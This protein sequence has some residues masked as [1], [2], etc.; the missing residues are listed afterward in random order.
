MTRQLAFSVRSG[1]W[2]TLAGMLFFAGMMATG[3]AYN[4]T[5]VQFGLLDLG[6]RLVGM[7]RQNLALSMACLAL[8]TSLVA[9][10]FGL[11]MARRSWGRQFQTKLRLAFGV[12]LGQ[13]LLTAVAPFIRSQPAFLAWIVGASLALGVGV[14]V[15][16]GMTVD[17]VPVRSRSYVAALITAGAYFPAAVVSADWTVETFAAGMVP[18]MVAGALALGGLAFG[19]LDLVRQLAAQHR[20]PDFGL[21]RFVRL[22]TTPNAGSQTRVERSLFVLFILMFGIYFVDSLGFLRLAETPLF[23]KTAWRSPELNTRLLIGSAHIVA[24]LIAGVLYAALDER[25]LFLWIFG[26]FALVHLMYTVSA[27]GAPFGEPSLAMPLLYAVA[28]SLYTVINFA[29]WADVSTPGTISRNA[30]LGVA[31]SAWTATFISTGLALQLRLSG[32]SLAAHLRLVDA[33]A[34]LFFL[35]VLLLLFFAPGTGGRNQEHQEGR[36]V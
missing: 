8:L 22:R 12:V 26:I 11:L 6:S 18:L 28:V 4:L 13:T 35:L 7:S 19:R 15:T 29:I 1:R 33:L 10:L 5:F 16:F 17:L 9:V 31:L 25:E 14:P 34:L 32:M 2:T 21:G 30:A 3:Y 24:A 27:R 20:R 36:A 23:F